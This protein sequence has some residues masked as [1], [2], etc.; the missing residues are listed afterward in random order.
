[1]QI[2][3]KADCS[4]VWW[5]VPHY[6]LF[7]PMFSP[8]M[9]MHRNVKMFSLSSTILGAGEDG[10]IWR[11]DEVDHR[12]GKHWTKANCPA[13]YCKIWQCQMDQ[14][15]CMLFKD[16]HDNIV[17]SDRDTNNFLINTPSILKILSPASSFLTD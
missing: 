16:M 15:W 7:S 6:I 3:N 1:M 13:S 9:H 5:K 12:S 11:W 4:V 2:A 14:A 8:W 10:T 17:I